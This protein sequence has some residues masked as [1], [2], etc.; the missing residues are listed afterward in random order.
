MIYSPLEQ[1]EVLIFG[2]PI[3]F[4]PKSSEHLVSLLTPLYFAAFCPI[5]VVYFLLVL[6][7]FQ[8][9]ASQ[10][11]STRLLFISS[12]DFSFSVFFRLV[13]GLL[14]SGL[15]GNRAVSRAVFPAISVVFFFILFSNVIGLF[16]YSFTLTGQFSITLALSFFLFC[17]INIISIEL[18]GLNFLSLFLPAGSPF[19]MALLLVPIELVS[20]F[21]RVL[22]LAIRL[23]A[24]MMA[25]HCLLKILAGF[26]WT[27]F[28]I[29][30]GGALNLMALFPFFVVFAVSF[31]EL[32]IAFLQAYVFVLLFII[33]L[34]D[35]VWLH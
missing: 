16:P 30:A 9:A 6:F 13:W 4:L 21:A 32:A 5:S 27:L 25:G 20:Y 18:H 10:Y 12:V 23:F 35:A 11:V 34:K 22:S 24:N 2:L 31:L 1:F 15:V 7:I 3:A 8:F 14:V 17:G 19:K 28:F 33:Y 29:P 26:A